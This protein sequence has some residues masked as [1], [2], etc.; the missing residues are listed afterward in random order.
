MNHRLFSW[1][2]LAAGVLGSLSCAAVGCGPP[3]APKLDYD[4]NKTCTSSSGH[5]EPLVV[6]W[7]PGQRIDLEAAMKEGVALVRYDCKTIHLVRGCRIDGGYGFM[8]TTTKEEVVRLVNADE[9]RAN[10]PLSG[11]KLG[12]ELGADFQRGASLDIALVMIGK[13]ATTWRSIKS[14]DLRGEGCGE[15]THFIASASIGAFVMQ[16]GQQS[17]AR[18]AVELFNAGGSVAT[19]NT[20]H[21]RNTDGIIDECKKASP[22]ADAPPQQCG[23]PLRLELIPLADRVTQASSKEAKTPRPASSGEGPAPEANTNADAAPSCPE[24]FALSGGKCVRPSQGGTFACKGDNLKECDEQCQK[25]E[26]NSCHRLAMAY[27]YG[28]RGAKQDLAA[29]RGLYKKACE[30]GLPAA[31]ADLGVAF[32]HGLGGPKDV[33]GAY[34]IYKKA[35]DDGVPVGC[36][37]LGTLYQN[38]KGVERNP[39]KAAKLYQSGCNGGHAAGCTFLGLKFLNGD[40]VAKDQSKAVRLF[41]QACR[42]DHGQACSLLAERYDQGQGVE[43]DE[44]QSFKYAVRGC[45]LGHGLACTALGDRYLAGRGI[46]PEGRQGKPVDN[47][48][49]LYQQACTASLSDPEGCNK[50]GVAHDQGKLVP[51]NLELANKLFKMGCE[52][53]SGFACRNLAINVFTGSGTKVDKANGASIMKLGC[54]LGVATACNDVGNWHYTGNG[55]AYDHKASAVYWEK[56]CAL[57]DPSSCLAL[58]FAF[59]NGD[60]V[61]KKPENAAKLYAMSCTESEY[62]GCINLGVLHYFG[63]GVTRDYQKAFNLF[64]LGCSKGDKKSC[65]NSGIMQ[66]QGEGTT[67]DEPKAV[68]LF[69]DLCE[70]QAYTEACGTLGYLAKYGKGFAKD[71]ARA[72]SY[73]ERACKGGDLN[74]CV[75]L[76]FW[77]DENP[78]A[79]KEDVA[80][81]FA[82]VQQACD[83]N[84]RSGC[85]FLG[86]MF[87][88]GRGT[89]KDAAR[90]T[91]L[92]RRSCDQGYP[93]ACSSLE[94]V[95]ELGTNG[96][97]ASPLL[98]TAKYEQQCSKKD[99]RACSQAGFQYFLG[100]GVK[101][102]RDKAVTLLRKACELDD[103]R[104][105]EQL[106]NMVETQK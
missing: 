29:A 68:E 2:Y 88:R 28:S 16:T 11:G 53:G 17:Q 60:G 74:A 37:W 21:V 57:K 39:A 40:S 65:M 30:G 8:A 104:A 51:K 31:C 91:S 85:A 15:V 54:E 43:R 9:V 94:F 10:L 14:T 97:P 89:T 101:R 12:A 78:T 5:G 23:A 96:V 58:G 7:Q 48:L 24:G 56:G 64:K 47:A 79:K 102:D 49:G 69:R 25:N 80:R 45:D 73:S 4:T 71:P 77:L 72:L 46:P 82:L 67:K 36:S 38:G 19:K 90:A 34:A 62:R 81:S 63:T 18:T 83:G 70:G 52:G 27:R 32:E 100:R 75:N 44:L 98:A 35:C 93:V 95:Q 106:K 76:S 41:E 84:D 92:Y 1:R 99:A 50:L 42:G 103:T 20:R 55:V 22:D 26:P 61:P 87:E 66:L 33:D 3:P 59:Q 105:C 13:K 86:Y 6:D